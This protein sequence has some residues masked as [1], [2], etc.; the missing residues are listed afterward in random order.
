MGTTP[1]RAATRA[2]GSSGEVEQQSAAP[3]DRPHRPVPDAP[4]RSATDIDET[5][6]RAVRPDPA[7]QGAR[8][9]ARRPSRPSRSSRPNGSPSAAGASASLRSSRPIRSSPGTSRRRSC[10]PRQRYGIGVMVWSPLAGGWLSGNTGRAATRHLLRP[11]SADPGRFDPRCRG[12]A[13]SGDPSRS[14]SSPRTRASRCAPG[15]R[16]RHRPPGVRSAII[17]AAHDGPAQDRSGAPTSPWTTRSGPDRQIV[18]A[19]RH[20]QRR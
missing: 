15:H 4:P 1:T 17:G 12:R 6:R 14:W 18:A 13:A 16:V 11:G 10:R 7:E 8:R 20:R 9:S 2:A 19:R 5:L 3:A